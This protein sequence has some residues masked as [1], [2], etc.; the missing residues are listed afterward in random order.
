MY[1]ERSH[2][3]RM[4]ASKIQL[5]FMTYLVNQNAHGKEIL[6]LEIKNAVRKLRVTVAVDMQQMFS[7]HFIMPNLLYRS[8]QLMSLTL[9][10]FTFSMAGSS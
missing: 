8:F 3:E 2:L 9:K 1:H 4:R 7:N 6:V 5:F 10:S